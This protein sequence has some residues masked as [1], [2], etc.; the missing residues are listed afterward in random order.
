MF[1]CNVILLNNN[2]KHYFSHCL[3][4]AALAWL[5]EHC[6]ML[7]CSLLVKIGHLM[8][9]MCIIWPRVWNSKLCICVKNKDLCPPHSGAQSSQMCQSGWCAVRQMEFNKVISSLFSPVIRTDE[10]REGG[11]VKRICTSFTCAHACSIAR[12]ILL[13]L[14]INNQSLHMMCTLSPRRRQKLQSH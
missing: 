8:I 14:L 3:S 11:V 1:Y 2:S 9:K 5:T 6:G 12:I 7:Y 4:E 10:T 13:K